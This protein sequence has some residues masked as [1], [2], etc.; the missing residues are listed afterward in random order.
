[1]AAP[2][3]SNEGEIISKKADTFSFGVIILEVVTG[4]RV[5][6]HRSDEELW[7]QFA[8]YVR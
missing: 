1:M 8:E 2:E 4:F 6:Y 3:Y 5:D 7:A